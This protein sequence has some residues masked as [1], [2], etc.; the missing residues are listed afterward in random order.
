MIKEDGVLLDVSHAGEEAFRQIVEFANNAQ[1]LLWNSP[2][3][4]NGGGISV[5]DTWTSGKKLIVV[6]PGIAGV[7]TEFIERAV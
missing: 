1:G 4:P 2:F 6:A 7:M 5:G 3:L